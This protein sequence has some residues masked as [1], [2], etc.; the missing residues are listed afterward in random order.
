MS[1][2]PK[3][4]RRH[5]GKRRPNE[6]S[7]ATKNPWSK[8]LSARAEASK[9]IAEIES[10]RSLQKAMPEALAR[11]QPNHTAL[12]QELVYGALR[13]WPRLNA[14][15]NALISKPL[16]SKDD[17]IKALIVLGLH[18]LSAMRVPAHAAISETVAACRELDKSWASGF[19]NGRYAQLV[20]TMPN[21]I[22]DKI[23][24]ILK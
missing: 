8:S 5:S 17:D 10:G 20:K 13:E 19:I 2:T 9:L 11:L 16:K 12:L 4:T 7:K 24:F 21:K 6:A 3:N 22:T 23:F 15:A 1:D 18:Q 14:I